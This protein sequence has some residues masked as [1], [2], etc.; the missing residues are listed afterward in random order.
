M[1]IRFFLQRF[2]PTARV[3]TE[4][5]TKSLISAAD[6][7]SDGKIGVEGKQSSGF[8]PVQGQHAGMDIKLHSFKVFV[9]EELQNKDKGLLEIP[10]EENMRSIPCSHP[11]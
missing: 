9:M 7:D 11:H 6:D 8:F 4:K 5:E 1:S 2:V 10:C 3:L